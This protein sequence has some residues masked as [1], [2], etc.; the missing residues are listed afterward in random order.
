VNQLVSSHSIA[1]LISSGESGETGKPGIL[2]TK[3]MTS[4]ND[5]FTPEKK[6][7]SKAFT[8][9]STIEC[10]GTTA[11]S[12]V[13]YVCVSA[14]AKR[15][16]VPLS[17][18]KTNAADEKLA[19]R[20]IILLGDDY[21]SLYRQ[22]ER[23]RDFP[24]RRLIEQPGWGA[25]YFALPSG[26]TFSPANRSGERP[27]VLFEKVPGKCRSK[28]THYEWLEHVAAPLTG[29]TLPTFA[30]MAMFAA[31]LLRIIKR[32]G[33]F[34]FELAGRKA[35]GKSTLQYI[36]SSV[37]GPAI[38]GRGR[39]Y[40]ISGNATV[41]GL[42]GVIPEHADLPMV[43]EEMNLFAA[44][45]VSKPRAAQFDALVWSLADGSV[46]ARHK[47]HGQSR[48]R[49]VYLTSTNEPLAVV[50]EGQ[51]KEVSS[52]AADRLLTL[53]VG[54]DRPH[55]VFDCIPPEYEDAGE[56]ATALTAKVGRYYGTAFPRYLQ[57]LVQDRH[58][59]HSA[60]KK[61]IEK[62]MAKFRRK[63]G[64]DPIKGASRRVAD[65]FGLVYA[66]GVLAQRYGAL[67]DAF[68]CLRAARCA[69]ELNRSITENLSNADRLMKLARR[70]DV[71]KLRSGRLRKLT[72]AEVERAAGFVSRRGKH[73]ELLLPQAALRR[74]FIDPKACLKDPEVKAMLNSDAGRKTVKRQLR[75]NRR[76]ERVYCFR[77]PRKDD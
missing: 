38:D 19:K 77:L 76:P 21:K 7:R 33:N 23:L 43:I 32:N 9:A 40:W 34:G 44:G 47:D 11:P 51:R 50:L 42:E 25:D 29:Q 5:N 48:Y 31:P 10:K 17:D 30:L 54:L 12:G 1:L 68:S 45:A 72:D 14:C 71:I 73:R 27:I 70:G 41:A 53:P 16:F 20:N 69:Y 64:V 36:A 15:A 22:I 46:K 13:P 8:R 62:L 58:D 35:I 3:V 49:F 67:P 57:G 2:R 28:G 65:A 39:N 6:P 59:S 4:K 55:G 24:P 60:L 52:A 61:R 18:F 56:L 37:A 66:A 63:V 75:A 74:V 26:A